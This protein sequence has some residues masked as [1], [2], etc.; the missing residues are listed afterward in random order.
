MFIKLRSFCFTAKQ[1]KLFVVS[2]LVSSCFLFFSAVSFAYIEELKNIIVDIENKIFPYF[3]LEEIQDCKDNMAPENLRFDNLPL[4]KQ[5]VR[6]LLTKLENLKIPERFRD[7]AEFL[8]SMI[9]I[10]QRLRV[11]K[12]CL[13]GA[14]PLTTLKKQ[15][16]NILKNVL[17]IILNRLIFIIKRVGFNWDK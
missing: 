17:E 13:N 5:L 10:L 1:L 7:N 12:K 6:R 16:Q 3:S 4:T 14:P 11:I 9:E 15:S 2:I 8:R